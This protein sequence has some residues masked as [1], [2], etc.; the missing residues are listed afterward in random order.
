MSR[1]YKHK[2]LS[3]R[4]RDQIA[5]SLFFLPW[6][7]GFFGITLYPMLYS[8][9]ISFH[10]VS[11]RPAGTKLTPMGWQYYL[12]ALTKDT[13]F[14]TFLLE[15]LRRI[16]I[17]APM[18]VIFSLIIALL[19]NKPFRGRTFFRVI[20]FL[21]V[22]IMSG[23]MMDELMNGTSAMTLSFGFEN[24]DAIIKAL[25]QVLWKPLMSFLNNMLTILW[26]SG[27]Q[28]QIFI[29][30]MQKI[31]S[32]MYE[33]ASIDGATAW[34]IFWRIIL[35][36]LRPTILLNMIYTIVEMGTFANDPINLKIVN[37]MVKDIARPFSYS[38]AMSWIY[39]VS[40]L[41]VILLTFLILND[42][43]ETR[44]ERNEKHKYKRQR[45]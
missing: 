41:F 44:R 6:V 2:G 8:I 20:F 10:E 18:V 22:V 45:I 17:G 39:A 28:T 9:V 19:L 42:W 31:D 4:Q 25:P 38:A 29:A 37:H 16:I 32:N 15:S 33:A 36:Y 13:E 27:V 24:I 3:N 40:L 5:G 1:Q 43:K 14:P 35:P 26:F 7:I 30:V 11:I 23:P 21:P 34:E 12:D